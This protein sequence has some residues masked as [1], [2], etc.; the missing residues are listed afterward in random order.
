[1]GRP[2]GPA[3]LAAIIA[4]TAE[5]ADARPGCKSVAVKIAIDTTF[6]RSSTYAIFISSVQ[7]AIESAFFDSRSRKVSCF[8]P[9]R[10]FEYDQY[11]LELKAE[12][13]R[14]IYV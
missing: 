11:I 12:F 14:Q 7:V 13:R 2:C 6:S 4:S 5:A 8:N 10:F 3:Y 1:M 9:R